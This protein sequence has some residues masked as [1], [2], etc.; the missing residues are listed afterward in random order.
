M[1][2][3]GAAGL[4]PGA[5]LIGVVGPLAARSIGTG[6]VG[7]V[8]VV[9]TVEEGISAAFTGLLGAAFKGSLGLSATGPA[10]LS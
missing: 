2:P 10:G 4:I 7:I 3:E 6:A 9:G 8:G 1:V 5:V